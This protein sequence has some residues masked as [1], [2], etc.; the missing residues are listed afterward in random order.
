MAHCPLETG[1]RDRFA[2]GDA[3]PRE[4]GQ[5]LRHLFSGCPECIEAVRPQ[6]TLLDHH[7]REDV[8]VARMLATM[9]DFERR[10]IQERSEAR[11][12]FGDFQ[13]HPVQRQWTLLR[14]SSRYGTHAFAELLLDASF[15][16]L[17]D[18]P[19]RALDLGDMGL[20][21]ATQLK[22]TFYGERAVRD[23]CGRAWG[24]V[25][26]ARRANSDLLGAEQAIA[27]AAK[28]LEEGSGE[29]LVEAEHHYFVASIH[30]S[31]RRFPAARKAITRSRRLY[32][33]VG[34]A[35]LEGRSLL[36]EALIQELDGDL[37]GAISRISRAIPMIDESRDRHLALG[38]R[39]NLL[40]CLTAAGKGA[41]AQVELEKLRPRYAE[42]GDK[43]SLIRLR[44]MEGRIALQL[45]R[46]ETA[47]AALR[48]S[49]EAFLAHEIPY[50]AATVAF[51]LA[52]LFADQGRTTELKTLAGELVAVFHRLGVAREALA[53]LMLFERTAQAEAVTATLVAKL[54]SYFERIRS[55]PE[56]AFELADAGS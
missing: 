21:V 31:Q 56:T 38:A 24:R 45:G 29:P 41:E 52:S 19:R 48:E 37:Q 6:V 28:Q 34:D 5:V 51:D 47:E 10:M 46:G 17:Y 50:E 55:E 53:A 11:E 3:D 16:A 54:A 12:L 49:H 40:W 1:V 26:N 44:W 35:H 4:R 39:H 18:D 7:R 42:I 22:D 14:N 15:E 32:R 36:N 30:R 9:A 20:F 8:S 43:M 25:A 13:K 2:A 23:L 27:T 33:L